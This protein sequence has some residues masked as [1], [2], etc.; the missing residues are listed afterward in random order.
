MY[1]S[2]LEKW[3][4]S[5]FN[6][7]KWAYDFPSKPIFKKSWFRWGKV[8][9]LI[10]GDNPGGKVLLQDETGNLESNCSFNALIHKVNNVGRESLAKN[11]K[12]IYEGLT[13]SYA[14]GKSLKPFIP[15]SKDSSGCINSLFYN[16]KDRD[17]GEGEGDIFIDCSYT[18]FFLE[19]NEKGTYRYLQNLSAYIGSAERRFN[20][21][22]GGI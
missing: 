20:I 19:M 17:N 11:L 14:K 15:F 8:E 4:L 21:S 12:K 2:I 3:R 6:G 10:E 1:D 18:K 5:F 13:V 7:R 9:F 16:G 22:N